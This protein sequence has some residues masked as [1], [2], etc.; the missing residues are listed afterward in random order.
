MKTA[1]SSARGTSDPDNRKKCEKYA[2]RAKLFG[3]AAYGRESDEYAVF[4]KIEQ[5]TGTSSDEDLVMDI[6]NAITILRDIDS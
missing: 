2:G 4:E 1:E 5:V 3:Q 6:R